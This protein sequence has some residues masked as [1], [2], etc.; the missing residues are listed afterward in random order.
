MCNSKSIARTMSTLGAMV[1]LTLLQT[2]TTKAQ[3]TIFNI[4]STDV[5]AKKKVYFD[6]DLL[7]HLAK[8]QNCGF[9]S[10]VPRVVV[11]VAKNIDAGVHVAVSDIVGSKLVE[12][13]PNIKW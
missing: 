3:S 1:L 8:H 7:S 11:G 12:V 2:H 10:Y 5:V 13:Q 6:F 4:P 9:Q